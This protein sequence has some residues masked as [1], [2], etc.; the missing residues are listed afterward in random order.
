M[1]IISAKFIAIV[2]KHLYTQIKK[3]IKELHKIPVCLV[4]NLHMRTENAAGK[5]RIYVFQYVDWGRQR[6]VMSGAT[7][8]HVELYQKVILAFENQVHKKTKQLSCSWMKA[9]MKT[10]ASLFDAS[11]DEDDATALQWDAWLEEK[12]GGFFEGKI[13]RV[14]QDFGDGRVDA[15]AVANTIKEEV[16][17]PDPTLTAL[18]AAVSGRDWN[19]ILS[20]AEA[21]VRL[22]QADGKYESVRTIEKL[23]TLWPTY[24]PHQRNSD[25]EDMFERAKMKFTNLQAN[26]QD[27]KQINMALSE[28]AEDHQ[29]L[30][31]Q[32]EGVKSTLMPIPATAYT[33]LKIRWRKL[34]RDTKLFLFVYNEFG[35][36]G[37]R[38]LNLTR[39]GTRIY[40]ER[41]AMDLVAMTEMLFDKTRD[42]IRSAA[43]L[44]FNLRTGRRIVEYPDTGP[45]RVRRRRRPRRQQERNVRP[46][47]D[48]PE[49]EIELNAILDAPDLNE[50]HENLNLD[51]MPILEEMEVENDE[52]EWVRLEE[53]DQWHLLLPESVN[54]RRYLFF[55]HRQLGAAV[56]SAA[57]EKRL[58]AFLEDPENITC[59]D[60][61]DIAC[62]TTYITKNLHKTPHYGHNDTTTVVQE[63][64]ER[65]IRVR[66]YPKGN[67]IV[68]NNPVMMLIGDRSGRAG[69]AGGQTEFEQEL[70]DANAEIQRRFPAGTLGKAVL[71]FFASS[72]VQAMEDMLGRNVLNVSFGITS[73]NC[74]DPS[75]Q[76]RGHFAKPQITGRAA[77]IQFGPTVL[78]MVEAMER[79]LQIAMGE[80]KWQETSDP[81]R[82]E[83]SKLLCHEAGV[84]FLDVK[85]GTM[86]TISISGSCEILEDAYA[87]YRQKCENVGRPPKTIDPG[88]GLVYHVDR[89]N[90]SREGFNYFMGSTKIGRYVTD[91]SEENEM[92]VS[93]LCT[94]RASVGRYL[95]KE[96]ILDIIEQ[97]VKAELALDDLGYTT[98]NFQPGGGSPG[99]IMYSTDLDGGDGQWDSFV[100][101]E[102]RW[103]AD[104]AQGARSVELLEGKEMDGYKAVLVQEFWYQRP[105][106][107]KM[108]HHSAAAHLVEE[109]VHAFDLPWSAKYELC[110]I[111]AFCEKCTLVAVSVFNRWLSDD[112]FTYQE[113]GD[114][115]R[116]FF[117][118][119]D[120]RKIKSIPI[121]MCR[122]TSSHIHCAVAKEIAENNNYDTV[123]LA[124]E[125]LEP[126]LTMH[127]EDGSFTTEELL[128]EVSCLPFVGR[129]CAQS[130]VSIAC[131]TGL[132]KNANHMAYAE[133]T[134]SAK[135]HC[136]ALFEMGLTTLKSVNKVIELVS[137]RLGV[138]A[139]TVENVLCKLWRRH[140]IREFIIPF[141]SFYALEWDDE[142]RNWVVRKRQWHEPR[143]NIHG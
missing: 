55:E 63:A 49:P 42:E 134:D 131:M 125:Q 15:D 80:E 110:Y 118:V 117:R 77:L 56:P 87:I 36:H 13:F 130:F 23:G 140:E 115:V 88:A 35:T 10:N 70:E 102:G 47:L 100:Q 57:V 81:D 138:P 22:L 64:L 5:C 84:G 50:D 78:Y 104:R 85:R 18:V 116:K 3:Y 124:L 86:I 75:P 29:E 129:F 67:T 114:V 8:N 106:L 32:V 94:D 24:A 128:K 90:D 71:E 108:L 37:Q 113:T 48:E 31:D 34:S 51:E 142:G 89:W 121:A 136:K 69:P 143:W 91:R 83:W 107:T 59:L 41:R 66:T 17:L 12:A 105:E 39:D 7:G 76:R 101:T 38:F 16:E 95:L 127:V 109:L 26:L 68:E 20:S 120:V 45:G 132:I 103:V 135:P 65:G 27:F 126:V 46:R 119:V 30:Y 98:S 21:F 2:Q 79:L 61:I 93:I 4:C 40:A 62:G 139:K 44:S 137:V 72:D 92:R 112:A 141:Q 1:K 25:R 9:N 60:I 19:K 82:E 97:E 122:E 73:D 28:I 11:D 58:G 133:V 123:I 14:I 96:S 53:T 52:G 111:S 99:I 74:L 54:R 6:S 43:E 33:A